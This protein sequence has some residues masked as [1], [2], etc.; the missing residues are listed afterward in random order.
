MNEESS[1]SLPSTEE[2]DS[3]KVDE[4]Y[5]IKEFYEFAVLFRNE[6]TNLLSHCDRLIQDAPRWDLLFDNHAG[7]SFSKTKTWIQDNVTKCEKLTDELIKRMTV[8]EEKIKYFSQK[9]LEDYRNTS[10]VDEL[11]KVKKLDMETDKGLEYFNIYR[12]IG[13]L[14]KHWFFKDDDSHPDQIFSEF[15]RSIAR[16]EKVRIFDT[17]KNANL[18]EKIKLKEIH[19]KE[20]FIKIKEVVSQMKNL[21]FIPTVIFM[22]REITNK[23][24]VDQ[25]GS[26]STLKIDED[27]SLKIFNSEIHWKFDEIVILNTSAGIWTSSPVN[28]TD[29]RVCV[30][31]TPNE[32]DESKM[33]ILAKTRANYSIVKPDAVK[34]LEF[35]LSENLPSPSSVLN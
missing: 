3:L 16:T 9:V 4:S 20:I 35:D 24:V 12:N 31:I 15:G 29:D 2:L 8:D 34:I 33:K 30:E 18:I 32:K 11:A 25:I 14:D 23:I 1:L 22:P 10:V 27:I 17:I 19:S 28:D 7:E 21:G 5:V 6:S 13:N 26:Y